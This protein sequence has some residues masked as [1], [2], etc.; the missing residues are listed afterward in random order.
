MRYSILFF[1]LLLTFSYSFAEEW[2]L[3]G[4]KRTQDTYLK[5]LIKTCEQDPSVS[6]D[7]C[8]LNTEL[9]SSVKIEGRKIVVNERWT[10]I[11]VPRFEAGSTGEAYG[12]YLLERNFLGLGKFAMLGG[13]FGSQGN[14]LLFFYKDRDLFH[15]DWT[16]NI[17]VNLANTEF[18]AYDGTELQRSF[19]E[20]QNYYRMGIGRK[21]LN[22]YEAVV[23]F[24]FMD[25]S[26]SR[27]EEY[28]AP[29]SAHVWMNEVALNYKN[30]NFKFYF[31]EGLEGRLSIVNDLYRSDREEK[32]TRSAVEAKYSHAVWRQHA[33]QLA[34]QALYT[35]K[36][37]DKSSEKYG[38]NVGG[39]GIQ[40]NGLWASRMSSLALDYQIPIKNA[41][42]GTWTIA[43]FFDYGVYQSNYT[44]GH[45]YNAYGL[46]GYLYLKEVAL[47]GLG[48]IAGYNHRFMKE[49]VS[50]SVGFKQ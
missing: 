17:I 30:S 35:T 19:K 40:N 12:L 25:S 32:V 22:N 37:S 8:L 39:R 2:Q 46:G 41:D 47:P 50:F 28:I 24:S 48:I 31:D 27:L 44:R 13:T 15:T 33:L 14:N 6:L 29:K 11:P 42:Y 4:N 16:S 36:T 10:M 34:W 20:R 9:F 3:V 49:F 38:G 18:E 45:D 23:S 1:S 26:F 43:P 21:F 5:H 7:Q